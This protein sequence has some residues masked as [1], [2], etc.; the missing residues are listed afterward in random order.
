MKSEQ[1]TEEI[2]L[3]AD[4]TLRQ[5]IT[6]FFEIRVPDYFFV[7]P[8]STT[9]KYHPQI[10]LGQ[11]G[12]VRHTKMAV[13][14]AV[15]LLE[16]SMWSGL[17]PMRDLIISALL[18]HD[19]FKCG[20]PIIEH[21]IHEHPALAGDKFKDFCELYIYAEDK[22]DQICR[23]VSSHMGQWNTNKFSDVTLPKPSTPQEKFVH[24]CDF[25]SSKKW[26]GSYE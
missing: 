4:S 25:I 20:E 15:D 6:D 26:I 8:A 2:N 12:L 5:I 11:G 9:G 7:I 16:L 18:I 1:L 17:L 13:R 21:T 14:V 22:I 19:T 24:L 10:S 3:I 23:M